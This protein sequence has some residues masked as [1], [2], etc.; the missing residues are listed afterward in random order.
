MRK[1]MASDF[2]NT[3]YFMFEDPKYRPGDREAVRAFRSAG[4]LF[5]VSTGRSLQG[6]RLA[7][8]D[9][10]HFDF[11]ILVSG[12]LVLDGDGKELYKNTVPMDY[13]K[14]LYERY[15]KT[16]ET[17]IQAN[18]TVYTFDDE[19]HGLQTHI[20]SFDDLDEADLYG[21][22]FYAGSAERAHEMEDEIHAAYGDVLTAYAN[23]TVVDV[24]GKGCSKGA[25]LE[26]VRQRLA[27]DCVGAIGDS[28]NDTSMLQAA[29]VSFTFDYAPQA[30]QAAAD[31]IVGS[32]KEALTYL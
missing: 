17:V 27:L 12:S 14:A 19:L 26:I 28:F 2:D 6:V 11:Y 30:V 20:D 3:L 21:I 10:V 16:S 31:H 5:G 24:V 7:A 22:S 9:D 25:A 4:G 32:V 8:L 13:V 15:G 18:D 29:D 23:T 1:G